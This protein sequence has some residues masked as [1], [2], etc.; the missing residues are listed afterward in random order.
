MA[1]IDTDTGAL[2]RWVPERYISRPSNILVIASEEMAR[3]ATADI[4]MRLA[5]PLRLDGAAVFTGTTDPEFMGN[6]VPDEI[7]FRTMAPSDGATRLLALQRNAHEIRE[8]SSN[9]DSSLSR[10]LRETAT[11][12]LAVVFDGVLESSAS[13]RA[14]S[15]RDIFLNGR[16]ENI[17]NI[18]CMSLP[19]MPPMMRSQFDF[20]IMAP[21]NNIAEIKTAHS[22]IFGMFESH[23]DLMDTISNL[24]DEQL[25][26]AK[27]NG[28]SRT[29]NDCLLTYTPRIYRSRPT[30][31]YIVD[32]RGRWDAVPDDA[33]EFWNKAAKNTQHDVED[34]ADSKGDKVTGDEE[35]T[36]GS[37]NEAESETPK[38]HTT[39][40]I[41][42]KRF[43]I[44]PDV[45]LRIKNALSM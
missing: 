31:Q 22:K 19:D 27:L 13:Y 41:Y 3:R 35:D 16:H 15:I 21:T 42:G 25:L 40:I 5:K 26:V 2:H 38:V 8:G 33:D 14:H 36:E 29:L 43:P 1:A 17:M 23:K 6:V 4:L 24:D 18:V 12:R 20:A 32:N 7:I 34:A 9:Q 28:K 37:G 10:A 45:I 11:D 44:R 30:T 39:G